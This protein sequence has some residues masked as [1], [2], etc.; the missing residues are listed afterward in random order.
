MPYERARE[1]SQQP[2]PTS[3]DEARA[4][5]LALAARDL[6]RAGLVAE[7]L[8]LLEQAEARP[9]ERKDRQSTESA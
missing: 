8:A 7:A 9:V 3:N 4:R 2:A 5:S 6:L 1:R